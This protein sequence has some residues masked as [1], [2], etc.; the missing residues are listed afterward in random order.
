MSCSMMRSVTSS[1][2]LSCCS[3]CPSASVSRW[4]IPDEGSS[5]SN[6]FGRSPTR[7][8]S[9]TIRRVP[10]ESSCICLRRYGSR[11]IA[12]TSSRACRSL[13]RSLPMSPIVDRRNGVGLT[14]SRQLDGL[15][16]RHC[17]EE[18]GVLERADQAQS[19][20][21]FRSQPGDVV[22][23]EDHASRVGLREPSE[24]LECRCLSGSVRSDEAHGLARKNLQR[25]SCN[26]VH[27]T[28]RLP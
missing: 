7:H 20:S 23:I 22:F 3:S 14:R 13:C 5:R 1:L 27:A 16:H 4:A 28:E 21:I 10:V 6:S 11:P 8:A 15:D 18:Y 12:E 25:D 24:Q 9:S 19:C 26:C 2:F 17:R